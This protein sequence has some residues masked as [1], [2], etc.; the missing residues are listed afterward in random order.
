D[1]K[2]LPDDSFLA[3][4]TCS[5]F[6]DREHLSH[7]S[8]L[9]FLWPKNKTVNSSSLVNPFAHIPKKLPETLGEK[10]EQFGKS[11]RDTVGFLNNGPNLSL[12][13]FNQASIIHY[14]DSYFNGF[15][16]GFDTDMV[17]GRDKVQIGDHFF[18]AMAVNN[19]DCFGDMVK[20]SRPNEK[21]TTDGFLFHQG[22]ID[23]LGLTFPGNHIVNQII[24][25]DNR[26][27][28]RKLLEKR[29]EELS[30]SSNFG[31]WNKALYDRVSDTLAQINNDASS[32]SVRGQL[33]VIFW[34]REEKELDAT[35]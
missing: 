21:Y 28:W 29:L 2:R 13:P 20:T 1:T 23:G 30:K 19:E 14:T 31:S 4:A 26:H 33:N 22:F 32:R 6:Q 27:K 18:G 12:K 24:H 11:V 35:G 3:K 10:A 8:L 9:F 25:L 5:H 7:E 16:E 17:L 15:N 34:A